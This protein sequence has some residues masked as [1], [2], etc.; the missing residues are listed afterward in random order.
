[1]QIKSNTSQTPDSSGFTGST[2]LVAYPYQVVCERCQ[3]TVLFAGE[4]GEVFPVICDQC[5]GL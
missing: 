2:P 5:S 4:N 1:M 3:K